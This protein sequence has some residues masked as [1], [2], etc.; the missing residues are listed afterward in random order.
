M[1]A[2]KNT[3]PVLNTAGL[4]RN[5][6]HS[7]FHRAF[8]LCAQSPA[9]V[10]AAGL[11]AL[12]PT[13][14]WMAQRFV[15]GSDDPLGVLAI[16]ALLLLLWRERGALDLHRPHTFVCVCV[17]VCFMLAYA[18][19]QSVLPPLL[20]ALLGVLALASV[21][22]AV[23]P[24][25]V[26]AAPVVGLS[27]LALPLLASLQ[28]YAGYPLRVVTAEVSRWLLSLSFEVSRSGSALMVDGQL[29]VVD[30]PCS[31]VQMV[32]L[33]YFSACAVAL[34]VGV[35]NRR[36]LARLPLVGLLVMAANVLRN[37]VLVS[38]QAAGY[39]FNA[40]QHS[41]VGLVALAAV[42]A[43][44]ARWMSVGREASSAFSNAQVK[45]KYYKM[46]IMLCVVWYAACVLAVSASVLPMPWHGAPRHAAHTSNAIAAPEMPTHWRGKPLRPLALS[47]VEERFAQGFPGSIQRLTTSRDT[48]IVRTIYQPTRM[49]HPAADCYRGLGYTVGEHGLERQSDGKVWQCFIATTP[50]GQRMKVCER[51]EDAA[52]NGF[53][54]TSSWYW[55]ALLQR[56]TAPWRAV[57]VAVPLRD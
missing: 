8:I 40:W 22:L 31:G 27:V 42:C 29:I 33:A 6:N 10:I 37:S 53:T 47:A 44:V 43:L 49:L 56:S 51:I 24:A 20:G 12:L 38:A 39:P 3:F 30:A 23:L 1:Y 5:R 13:W 45:S 4:G 50:N 28:F 19:A 36:F 15:D 52:G 55:Q 41:A 26:A 9:V 35:S 54:D 17:A 48:L 11:S 18:V 25:R 34:Y 16:A 7:V 32:W 46:P 2:L 57:T 21:V 14:I